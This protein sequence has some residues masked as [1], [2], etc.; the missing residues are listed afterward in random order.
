MKWMDLRDKDLEES[1]EC[2]K[3]NINSLKKKIKR[4]PLKYSREY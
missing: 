2:I 4:I 1:K 3:K